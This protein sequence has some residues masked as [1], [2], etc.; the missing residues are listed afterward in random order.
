VIGGLLLGPSLL[1]RLAPEAFARVFSSVNSQ[2]VTIMSQ[3]GLVLLMFQIGLEFDFSH[4][5]ET[6]NRRA[7]LFVSAAGIALPFALGLGLGIMSAAQL[8]P[9]IPK[10]GYVLFMATALSITA[11]PVLGRI[12]IEFSLHRTTLGTIAISAAAVN[13]VVGWILLAVISALSTAQ[14]SLAHVTKQLALLALYAGFC[15]WLLRPLLGAAL[16]SFRVRRDRLPPNLMAF[17]LAL[18][19]LSAMATYTLGIFAIFGGFMMGVLLYDRA[20]FVVAWKERVAPFVTVF[21][22]PIFFTYTGLRTNVNGLNTLPLWAWCAAVIGAGTL[23][24]YGGCYL[25]GRLAGLS[26]TDS[27]CI[28]AMMNTRGLMELV[29]VNVGYDLGLIPAN[30][31]TILVLMAVVSTVMTAPVLRIL[32]PLTGHQVPRLVEA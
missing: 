2:P 3:I 19:F 16:R 30:V 5:R 18:A 9:G 22:L 26:S 8:A 12:M 7:V 29:I 24:K 32:L 15:W 1:G 20:E 10:L 28:G 31:F 4:L 27:G 14:F 11:I 25:A 23:G 21:F 13:D 6:R 17:V